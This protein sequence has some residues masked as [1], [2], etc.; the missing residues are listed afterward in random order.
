MCIRDR[1]NSLPYRLQEMVTRQ[2]MEQM[3]ALGFNPLEPLSLDG[4]DRKQLAIHQAQSQEQFDSLLREMKRLD[5]NL[6]VFRPESMQGHAFWTQSRHFVDDRTQGAIL[7]QWVGEK[8]RETFT[9]IAQ[10][11]TA[12]APTPSEDP[13]PPTPEKPGHKPK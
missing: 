10:W 6:P 3:Y 2:D 13:A 12:R 7:G 5:P 9:S 8:L 4:S 11:R 1:I